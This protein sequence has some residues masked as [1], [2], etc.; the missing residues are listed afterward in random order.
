MPVPIK[1]HMVRKVSPLVETSRFGSSTENRLKASLHHD[2]N[3]FPSGGDG[4]LD[5]CWTRLSARA[6]QNCAC[7][8]PTRSSHETI[9]QAVSEQ[10]GLGL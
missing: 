6:S 4:T 5:R 3:E 9:R 8:R 7:Q 2:D 10:E 1:G